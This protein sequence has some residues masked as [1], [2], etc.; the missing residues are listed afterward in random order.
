[1][2]HVAPLP[3]PPRVPAVDPDLMASAVFLFSEY[4]A[5]RSA[6]AAATGDGDDAPDI[7]TRAVLDLFAE[8]IGTNV[9]TTLNLYLRVTALYRLLASS[10]SLMRLAMDDEDTGGALT[11]DATVAAARL[12]LHVSRM[13]DDGAAEFDPR[14]FRD[15]IRKG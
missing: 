4:L 10:P 2:T 8:E 5:D 12:D 3:V 7:E 11:E 13:N 9:P 1:M 14:E 6:E 15:A